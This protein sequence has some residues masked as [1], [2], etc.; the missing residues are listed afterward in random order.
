MSFVGR[1]DIGQFTTRDALPL[2]VLAATKIACEFADRDSDGLLPPSRPEILGYFDGEPLYVDKRGV[3]VKHVGYRDSTRLFACLRR[4]V[5]ALGFEVMLGD[6]GE[7]WTES[8]CAEPTPAGDAFPP[9]D[10][11]ILAVAFGGGG[12]AVAD[13]VTQRLALLASLAAQRRWIVN[14]TPDEYLVP[15]QLLEDALDAARFA[16]LPQMRS[17]LPSELLLALEQLVELAGRVRVEGTSNDALVELDPAWA[18][19]RKQSQI[20]LAVVG[21]DLPKWEA[22]EALSK[23]AESHS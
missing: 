11:R 3:L 19:V 9:G 2:D 13:Y 22:T 8:A 16:S 1:L 17:G 7:C 10:G 18:A 5:E 20:C 21:F 6:S 12:L 4:M 15:Q 23:S 14:G